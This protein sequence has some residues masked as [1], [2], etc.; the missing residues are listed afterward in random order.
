M[1]Y[2]RNFFRMFKTKQFLISAYAMFASE[3]DE[4]VPERINSLSETESRYSS[5][6]RQQPNLPPKAKKRISNESI[7]SKDSSWTRVLGVFVFAPSHTT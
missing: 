7:N 6:L 3:G 2:Q 1:M 4:V 5:E